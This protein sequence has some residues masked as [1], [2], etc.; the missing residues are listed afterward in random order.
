MLVTTIPGCERLEAVG[1]DAYAMTLSA[2]VGSIKGTYQGQVRLGDKK[3]PGSFV[4]HA[5]GAGGPGTVSAEVLVV[6][7]DAGTA[8]TALSYDADAVV[9]GT[10]GGVGQRM[11]TGVAKRTA[12]EFFAAVDRALSA[13]AA[14]PTA[15]EQP[16]V[17]D[18]AAGPADVGTVFT[19]PKV[20]RPAIGR[21]SFQSGALVG[22]AAALLGVLVG[23]WV[24]GR[25]RT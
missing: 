25:R 15:A 16:A 4:L 20:S 14:A 19:A 8:A 1:D 6:L 18:A 7:E 17:S 3:H 24:S 22:A 9:G 11:L 2:G 21:G 13:A 12:A 5:S 10:I 23:A